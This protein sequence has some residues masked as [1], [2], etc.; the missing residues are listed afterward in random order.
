MTARQ[1]LLAVYAGLVDGQDEAGRLEIEAQL[2][3]ASP[4]VQAHRRAAV[5]AMGGEIG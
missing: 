4:A 3:P 1:V 5:L 2:D